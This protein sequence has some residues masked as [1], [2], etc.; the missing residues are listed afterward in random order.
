MVLMKKKR[1]F[2]LISGKNLL[3]IKETCKRVVLLLF[4]EGLA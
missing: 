4:Q 3:R 1:D 2:S